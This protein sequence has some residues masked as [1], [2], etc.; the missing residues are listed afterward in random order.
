MTKSLAPQEDQVDFPRSWERFVKPT[1]SIGTARK[2]E[3]RADEGAR[4]Y[5]EHGPWLR[6][7]LSG[8]GPQYGTLSQGRHRPAALAFLDGDPEPLGAAVATVMI[9]HKIGGDPVRLDYFHS[10]ADTSRAMVHHLAATYGLPFAAEAA[11]LFFTLDSGQHADPKTMPRPAQLADGSWHRTVPDDLLADLRHLIAAAT[12][13]D[14]IVAA[15]AR[16]RTDPAERLAVTLLVPDEID[17]ADEVCHEHRDHHAGQKATE[18]LVLEAVTTAAQ[19]DVLRLPRIPP[20]HLET[21]A[22]AGL[23]RRV[24]AAAAPILIDA[25]TDT[26]PVAWRRRLHKALA[27]LPSD[28]AVAYFADRLDDKTVLGPALLA[29][30]RF[31]LRTLRA[32]AA[33]LPTAAAPQRERLTTLARSCPE[34]AAAV[35]HLD[36]ESRLIVAPLFGLEARVPEADSA[37]LPALLST[38]PWTVKRPKRTAVVIAGLEPPA[39]NRVV[40]AEGERD[41]WSGF[42][43]EFGAYKSEAEWRDRARE[44]EAGE[45]DSILGRTLLADAPIAIAAPLAGRWRMEG[46]HGFWAHEEC[47]R[48]LSRFGETVAE[49]VAKAAGTETPWRDLALPIANRTAARLMADAF[50]RLKSHRATA[51]AWLDRHAA[52]AAVLL[53]PDALGPDAKPRK[54]AEAALRYLVAK[55]GPGPVREA[56]ARYGAEAVEALHA[57]TDPDPLALDAKPPKIGPWAS[58]ALLPQVLLHG[59]ERAL[60]LEAAEHLITILALATPEHPFAGIEV[61]AEAC[62]RDSLSRFSLALFE[63]WLQGGAPTADIWALTQLAHFA[64]DDTVRTLAP[65]VAAWPGSN[66]HQRAVK[67]LQVLGAIGTE[68]ALRAI[69]GIAEKAKF[70]GIRWEAGEQIR[71]IAAKLGLT[72]EQLADRLVPDF[73]LG[74]QAA[75][76]LDYGGRTFT[77]AFDEQLK[78]YVVDEQGKR[79]KALPKPGVKDDA[80]VADDA[81]RRFAA[82]KKDLRTVAADLV[83]RLEAAM[84][85]GRNWS[86][87]EFQKYYVDHELTGRLARRLVWLAE[88]DGTRT[89][90]R[91]AEDGTFG[92]VEDATFTLPA[93]AT[94]RVAHPALLAPSE[95]DAW[96]EIL[97]DYE[98]LQPF[99]QLDRPVLGFTE[100]ELATGRLARFEGVQV[101]VGRIL[102]MTARGWY[103]AAT[104]RGGVEPGVAYSLLGSGYVVV[105]LDPGLYTGSVGELP[106]QTITAVYLSEVEEYGWHRPVM[107]PEDL[108]PVAVAE[109]LSGLV[110]LTGKS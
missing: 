91:I 92:D 97:A 42:D 9:C 71:S 78:P 75:L 2:V 45:M 85:D 52:D 19:L 17:W 20:Y 98:I 11:A 88:S 90:F 27:M 67:G 30:Q 104:G 23:I 77:V 72:A 93:S 100:D 59:G 29:A 12:D 28:E 3:L 65:L 84:I 16:R 89:G 94:I 107:R 10:K 38:P 68:T 81:Y 54:A 105:A 58:P 41:E 101:E 106:H 39:I 102:G 7:T 103:R 63:R 53:I 13:Y 56:A 57:I 31:P 51:I 80:A 79:R 49:E 55:H 34:V 99:G 33:R 69:Q 18:L 61:V 5:A 44:C 1:R 26:H 14:A 4:R 43:Y 21:P 25:V 64:D 37:E 8:I 47:K 74:D 96:A 108:D 6:Q 66:H 62:D 36:A 110:R 95:V 24:G 83:K 35:R 48:I 82:L 87:A 73:G 60:P 22:T 15:L 50:V 86:T 32:I 76:V 109:A 70:D 46:S 40:W